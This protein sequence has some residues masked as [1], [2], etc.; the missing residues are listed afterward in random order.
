MRNERM[1][2]W[3]DEPHQSLVGRTPRDA[4]SGSQRAEVVRLLRQI[5]NSA[6]RARR[7]GAASIDTARLST[8]LGLDENDLAA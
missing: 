5:E 3:L 4:A 2:R 8:A 6:D 1:Q 7:R